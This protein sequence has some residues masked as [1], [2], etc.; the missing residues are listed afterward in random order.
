RAAVSSCRSA[1]TR[2]AASDARRASRPSTRTCRRRTSASSSRSDAHRALRAGRPSPVPSAVE[3]GMDPLVWNAVSRSIFGRLPPAKIERLLAHAEVEDIPAGTTTYR[4][5]GE[6]RAILIV[7]G[8]YRTY[9]VGPDGRQV[10]I[11]YAREGDV[12]GMAATAT[13]GPTPVHAQALVATKRLRLDLTVV[14]ALAHEDSDIAW[15]IIE[16]LAASLY[17]AWRDVAAATFG[18]VQQR[19]ARHLLEIAAQEQNRETPVLIARVSQRELANLVGSVREVVARALR[20][21]R[22]EGVVNVTKDGI[23]I[24]DPGALA[25]HAW[26]R[27]TKGATPHGR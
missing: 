18:S 26:P 19:V 1:A 13:S 20:E 10:T 6:P 7:S 25:A 24:T 2:R 5:T 27:A 11:R 17:A 4:A 16:D 22:D 12:L 14:R 23:V 3:A 15:L 9:V 21:F 8:L